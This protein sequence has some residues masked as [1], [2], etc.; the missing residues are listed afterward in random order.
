VNKP[1]L[2][3]IAW[4]ALAVAATGLVVLIAANLSLGS[5]AIDRHVAHEYSVADPQFART[6][7]VMLG[8]ALLPGNRAQTLLNGDE[9]FP[10]MLEA[11]RGA[12]RSITFE[13]YIYWQGKVGAEFTEALV[14]RARAGVKVHFMYDALGSGKIDKHY[15]EQ[16]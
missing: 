7:N 14:E 16:M 3:R 11:I 15:V 4:I 13:T 10:A 12:R 2:R 6:M 8:P 9:I 5:K 1:L